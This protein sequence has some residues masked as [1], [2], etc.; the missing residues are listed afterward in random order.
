VRGFCHSIFDQAD[1]KHGPGGASDPKF[2]RSCFPRR[3][4]LAPTDAGSAP[5]KRGWR[6]A[7]DELRAA[8]PEL[9]CALGDE[10]RRRFLSHLRPWWDVHRH[11][12]AP[13]IADRI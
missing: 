5:R 4:D 2:E 9:W 3:A 7:V 8:T 10:E 13:A 1:I 6:A 12:I 11:R